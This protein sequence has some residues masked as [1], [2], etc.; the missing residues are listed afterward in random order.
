M[1]EFD[2]KT[3][4]GM[5]FS[6]IHRAFRRQMDA[7]LRDFDLTGPQFGILGRLHFLETHGAGEINQRDIE[8]A[9]H[10]SHTTV[11]EML[12]RL[13]SKGF[14]K[15]VPSGVDRRS[16]CISS[17]E[18][19]AALHK[20]L[21]RLDTKVYERLCEGLSEEQRESLIPLVDVMLSNAV[22]IIGKGSIEEEC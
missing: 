8:N 10:L 3:P 18:K 17:T 15:T 13:E 9:T 5:R 12:K 22:K 16:K 20:E 1:E 19:A 7:L 2:D 14:I 21:G 11:T 4:V 6:V